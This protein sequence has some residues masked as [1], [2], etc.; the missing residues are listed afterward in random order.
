MFWA[1]YIWAQY[2]GTWLGGYGGGGLMVVLDDLNGIFQPYLFYD[3]VICSTVD[4]KLPGGN[5]E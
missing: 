3:S 2:K 4:K 1:Q 5:R